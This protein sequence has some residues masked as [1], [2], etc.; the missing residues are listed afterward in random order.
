MSDKC[1]ASPAILKARPKKTPIRKALRDAVWARDF[2]TSTTG[3]CCVCGNTL[4]KTP[5]IE[6]A[7]GLGWHACHI[8][9]EA[10]GGPTNVDNLRVGCGPCN[11]S[12]GTMDLDV[13]IAQ[14]Q[15]KDPAGIRYSTSYIKAHSEQHALRYIIFPGG[16][17]EFT[18]LC[19]Q[20][21]NSP[22]QSRKWAQQHQGSRTVVLNVETKKIGCQPDCSKCR[23]NAAKVSRESA[24]DQL[25]SAPISD[26][27]SRAMFGR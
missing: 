18:A 20:I 23:E 2:G 26:G 19:E 27:L 5:L 16:G 24:R 6:G 7:K 15:S 10:N 17:Q 13:L 4:H 11:R 22:K 14:M 21:A 3:T 9:A 12:C 8:V 1:P 25:Q